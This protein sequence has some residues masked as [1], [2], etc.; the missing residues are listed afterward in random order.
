MA[1]YISDTEIIRL[2]KQATP[3]LLLGHP[4]SDT[5]VLKLNEKLAVKFGFLL[6]EDEARNQ[7]KAYEILDPGIVRVPR[8]YRY[9]KGLDKYGYI[10]M[11]YM[12]GETKA[13]ITE[14]DQIC[15]M[16]QILEH[17]N[18]IK[19][20]KPGPLI[21]GPSYC[22]LFGDSDPPTFSSL[23]DMENWFNV[24]LLDPG[25][26]ISFAGLDLV[27]CHLDLFPRNILWLDCHPP[28]V[29]DWSSA[30]FYPRI[31]ERCSQLI[32]QQPEQNRVILDQTLSQFESV[33]VDLVLKAWWN[34]VR[35]C[36]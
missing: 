15:A 23:E 22:F 24:R 9:F 4:L 11:D 36:L 5:K 34:N 21:G 29:V 10:V 35:Y 30:G 27:F 12:E 31:F 25:A 6:D 3:D 2:C 19:S 20:P 14:S 18:S 7:A 17:F 16:S 1:D 32:T 28:C 13:S 8:V 33:Q 26:K